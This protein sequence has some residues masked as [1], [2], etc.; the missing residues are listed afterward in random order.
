MSSSDSGHLCRSLSQEFPA[1]CDDITAVRNET[2]F[3]RGSG[4]QASLHGQPT[5]HEVTAWTTLSPDNL[6]AGLSFDFHSL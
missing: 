3:S 1:K 6:I 4:R 2:W 5:V